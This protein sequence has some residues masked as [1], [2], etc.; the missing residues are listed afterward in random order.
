MYETSG[1]IV[2]FYIY[3]NWLKSFPQLT[4]YVELNIGEKKSHGHPKEQEFLIMTEKCISFFS[5]LYVLK[6][7]YFA[8]NRR[9]FQR[10][11]G[12]RRRVRL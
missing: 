10:G 2:F 5:L 6:I 11:G 9:F 8:I 4:P 12:G 1:M 7:L 3:F